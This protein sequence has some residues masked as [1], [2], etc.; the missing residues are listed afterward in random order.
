[1]KT[2]N[3]IISWLLALAAVVY[4]L[5]MFN[6]ADEPVAMNEPQSIP[7]AGSSLASADF[8]PVVN[9]PYYVPNYEENNVKLWADVP[10]FGEIEARDCFDDKTAAFWNMDFSQLVIVCVLPGGYGLIYTDRGTVVRTDTVSLTTEVEL[11]AF[12][13]ALGYSR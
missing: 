1:M 11:D 7:L 9:E 6:T 12:M 13:Q 5:S 10:A 3:W 2:F 4:A 8:Q